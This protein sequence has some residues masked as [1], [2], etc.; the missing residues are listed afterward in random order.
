MNKNLRGWGGQLAFPG[1]E[2]PDGMCLVCGREATAAGND[3]L[4]ESGEDQRLAEI[5][6]E[7]LRVRSGF[8]FCSK[9]DGARERF[10]NRG[11]A[12][13]NLGFN[14]L[15]WAVVPEKDRRGDRHRQGDQF[16]G[17][18]DHLGERCWQL[19]PEQ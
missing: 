10:P 16:R 19:R 11:V 8:G 15:V 2:L 13:S 1:R 7:G 17:C 12:G 9:C 14:R 5:H 18:C 3:V 4:G 6:H